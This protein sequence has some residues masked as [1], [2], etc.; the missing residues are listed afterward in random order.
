MPCNFWPDVVSSL[1]K[2]FGLVFNKGR[3]INMSKTIDFIK[4]VRAEMKHVVWPTRNQTLYATLAVLIV[5]IFVAY[6]LGLF[7]FL[8]ARGLERIVSR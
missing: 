5:S 1:Y 4:E 2:P 3:K 7:D 6:Y 8:F